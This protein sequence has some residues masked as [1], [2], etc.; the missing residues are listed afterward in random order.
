MRRGKTSSCSCLFSMPCFA[1]SY[2]DVY[3][4]KKM[5]LPQNMNIT[6]KPPIN[7]V[8]GNEDIDE[9]ARKFLSSE[10]LPS[11]PVLAVNNSAAAG[12]LGTSWIICIL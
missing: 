12:E 2:F 8:S 3:R 9:A 11:A 10:I 6:K 1:F 4:G 5:P 7:H